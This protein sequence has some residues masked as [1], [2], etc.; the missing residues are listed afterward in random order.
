MA[1]SVNIL[2]LVDNARKTSSCV[3]QSWF[4]YI[5][6]NAF[7]DLDKLKLMVSFLALANLLLQLAL[8]NRWPVKP[9]VHL[10]VG[11]NFFTQRITRL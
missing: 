9:V 11:Y 5:M 8:K 6:S 2:N 10:K 1:T 3:S 7:Q 4:Q